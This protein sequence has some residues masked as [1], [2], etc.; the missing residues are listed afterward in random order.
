MQVQP[1][2][3]VASRLVYLAFP[4]DSSG[5]R[6][7]PT[8]SYPPPAVRLR[9]EGAQEA[10]GRQPGV[11]RFRCVGIEGSMPTPVRAVKGFALLLPWRVQQRHFGALEDGDILRSS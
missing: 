10:P 11:I 9:D 1:Q 6:R 4:I 8:T 7:C 5:Q 3:F 2:E